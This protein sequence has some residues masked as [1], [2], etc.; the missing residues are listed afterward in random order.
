VNWSAGDVPDVPLAVFTVTST[1]PTAWAGAVTVIEV[2]E[3]TVKLVAAAV[4]KW[5]ALAPVK[6]LPLIVT[7]V[8]PPLGPVAGVTPVTTGPLRDCR[9][10]R[11]LVRVL[12]V[13]EIA[14]ATAIP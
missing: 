13:G 4:P 5:M 2:S 10:P 12:A 9:N 14:P 6:P 11:M 1:T 7:T 3:F 8:P